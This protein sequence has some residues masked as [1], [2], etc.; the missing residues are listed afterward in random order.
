MLGSQQ[1]CRR[2]KIL[3]RAA[4]A[5]PIVP[6]STLSTGAGEVVV[7]SSC[8]G[9][10][11]LSALQRV[12]GVVLGPPR[13]L[14][15]SKSLDRTEPGRGSRRLGALMTMLTG[16]DFDFDFVMVLFCYC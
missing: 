13:S 10:G 8:R 7:R 16:T 2:L 15:S 12:G 11:F 9:R 1:L 4:P 6:T 5:W 3:R 14:P